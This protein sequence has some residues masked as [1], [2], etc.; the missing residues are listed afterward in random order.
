M[1]Q[2]KSKYLQV[3]YKW[4]IVVVVHEIKEFKKIIKSKVSID[5]VTDSDELTL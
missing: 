4:D 3:L 1:S 2:W 5:A